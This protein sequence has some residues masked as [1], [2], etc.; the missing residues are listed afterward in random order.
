MQ[1]KIIF[2]LFQVEEKTEVIDTG[3]GRKEQAVN[4]KMVEKVDAGVQHN[5][6]FETSFEFSPT[7][8][9]QET[10]FSDVERKD[11][12]SQT[13]APHTQDWSGQVEVGGKVDFGVQVELSTASTIDSQCQTEVWQRS[14]S[15]EEVDVDALLEAEE[16]EKE[17]QSRV[18]LVI[19]L[20]ERVEELESLLEMERRTKATSRMKRVEEWDK[21]L[22]VVRLALQIALEE[23]NLARLELDATKDSKSMMEERFLV[24]RV[25]EEEKVK[26]AERRRRD[27]EVELEVAVRE[28]AGLRE[29]VS[30]MEARI[31]ELEGEVCLLKL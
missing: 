5:G 27:L 31:E 2:K 29:Q 18:N 20:E 3:E 21:E 4:F 1:R 19:L 8:E 6:F 25:K 14:L 17:E 26:E 15:S 16:K 11:L 28:S 7:E 23:S 30:R 13:S 22:R 24:E 9:R 10:K 12:G